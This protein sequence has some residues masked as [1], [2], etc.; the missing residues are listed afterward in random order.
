MIPGVLVPCATCGEPS[1]LPRCPKHLRATARDTR[2]EAERSTLYDAAWRRLSRRARQRQ[3]FCTDCGA[4]S[5]LTTDHLPE[6][7]HARASGRSVTLRMVE[8]VCAPC[9]ARRGP[10]HPGSDRYEAWLAGRT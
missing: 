9:N 3:P 5:R 10:A 1:E 8:V 6:A 2:R 7:H 4:T